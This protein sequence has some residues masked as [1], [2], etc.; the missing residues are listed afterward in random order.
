MYFEKKKKI[1]RTKPRFETLQFYAVGPAE[2][3]FN[4]KLVTKIIL[5]NFL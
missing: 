1:K 4:G 3:L 2:F 5:I